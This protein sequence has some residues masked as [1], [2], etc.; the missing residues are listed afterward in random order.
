MILKDYEARRES[1]IQML[2]EIGFQMHFKPQG[3]VFVFAELPE[4]WLLSDIEFVK[5]LIKKAGVAAV[6]GCGFFH[7]SDCN[8]QNQQNR[9]VRFAFCKSSDTLNA[10]AG[11]MRDIVG[12]IEHL[13]LW[14]KGVSVEQDNMTSTG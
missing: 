10:A 11:K 8:D 4:T 7:G 3:S 1:I 5:A 12:C 6:P 2:S 13:Q 9:Y 14:F